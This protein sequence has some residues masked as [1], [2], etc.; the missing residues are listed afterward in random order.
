MAGGV[1]NILV[2][3]EVIDGYVSVKKA[4]L[5]QGLVALDAAFECFKQSYRGARLVDRLPIVLKDDPPVNS[6]WKRLD[7]D[8]S[9]GPWKSSLAPWHGGIR[10]A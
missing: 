2:D 7:A 5:E 6:V 9:W 1:T 4:G 10:S 3:H 8:L